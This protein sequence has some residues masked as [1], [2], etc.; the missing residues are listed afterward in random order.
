M[1]SPLVTTTSTPPIATAMQPTVNG[2]GRSPRVS[3]TA[4]AVIGVCSA[5]MIEACSGKV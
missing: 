3:Q 5:M 1:K 2:D 4:S